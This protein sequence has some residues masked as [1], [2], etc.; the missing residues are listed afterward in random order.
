MAIRAWLKEDAVGGNDAREPR[1]R[2]LLEGLGKQ[3]SGDVLPITVHNVSATG[4]LLE[5]GERLEVGAPLW[6]DLPEGPETEA[7]VVWTSGPLHGCK[8]GRPLSRATLS[9]ALLRSAIGDEVIGLPA[10]KPATDE[11]LGPRLRR[12]RKA[13]GLTLADLAGELNV[14]KPTVWAWEQGRSAPT[15][16]RHERIAEVLDISV[17]DLRTGRDGDAAMAVL[18]RSRQ[19]IAESYGVDVEQVRIMIEL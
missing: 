14:S 6:M 1:R 11:P 5:C 18:E 17:S 15:P 8:F 12:L 10:K 4:M 2:V 7:V 16:D 19:Q 9:A 13:R 3:A